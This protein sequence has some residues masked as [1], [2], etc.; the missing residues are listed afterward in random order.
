MRERT[1][2]QSLFLTRH[3][4]SSYFF[5]GIV[6]VL[7]TITLII[8]G[9][10]F[11]DSNIWDGLKMAGGNALEFCE[12]NHWDK[13]VVQPANTWSNLGFLLVGLFIFVTGFDDYK[14]KKKHGDKTIRNLIA[15]YPIFSFLIGFSCIYLF[16]GSFLYHA[17]VRYLPQKLDIT[18]MYFLTVSLLAFSLFRSRFLDQDSKRKTILP[19]IVLGVII[20][21]IFIFIYIME[22]NVNLLFPFF[23]IAVFLANFAYALRNNKKKSMPRITLYLSLFV[24]TISFTMWILDREDIMCNSGS[25]FQGHAIWHVLNATSILLL[26][27]HYRSDT[28]ISQ[29]GE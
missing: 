7:I 27:M 21:N 23:I 8:L 20:A 17:S 5:G 12:E 9:S 11:S 4:K 24:M 25:I 19:W 18:S 2:S 13:V 6:F 28:R 26:Y 3:R 29:I 1:L 10:V 22:I 15:Q 16:L 14:I